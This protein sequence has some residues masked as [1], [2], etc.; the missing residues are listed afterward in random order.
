LSGYR[1]FLFSI[2]LVAFFFHH[3]FDTVEALADFGE[4]SI[5]RRKAKPNVIGFAEIRD[6]V[7]FCDEG[8]V[9][10]VAVRVA[11]G[12]VGAALGRVTRGTEGKAQWREQFIGQK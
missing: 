12:D 10:A 1:Q 11:D 4:G 3:P 6:D 8:A 2:F 5:E 9:D 7:H